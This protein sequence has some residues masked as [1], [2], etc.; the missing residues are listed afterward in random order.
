MP[1]LAGAVLLAAFRCAERRARDPLLP[2]RFLLDR[3]R[4]LALAAIALSACGTSMTFAVLSLHLQQSRDWSPLQTPAAFVPFAVALIT[5]GRAAG[6]LIA[7]YGARSVTTAGLGMGG[8]GLAVLALT[9][10]NAHASYAYGLPPGLVLLPAGAAA[11]FAGA[12]VLA[13][14][15]VPQQQI[16]L[17]SG[18]L[19]TAM[20]FGPTVLFAL[21]PD[22]AVG[23]HLDGAHQCVA[24]VRADVV[25]V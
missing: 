11:S 22:G 10:I 6:P 20:E 8:V 14:A 2:P 19:N 12:A 5:S 1:L 3:R 7:R 25:G 17:V 23:Y 24:R 9:G 18:V 4:A 15:G 16:G 13:T 21:L